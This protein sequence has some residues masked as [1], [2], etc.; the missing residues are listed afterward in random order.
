M[1]FVEFH[2]CVHTVHNNYKQ[3]L[4]QKVYFHC[5]YCRTAA[6]VRHHYKKYLD[7]LSLLG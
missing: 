2:I 1:Y 3:T 4:I 7:L 5:E 6:C